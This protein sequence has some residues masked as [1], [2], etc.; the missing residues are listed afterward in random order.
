MNTR[1]KIRNKARWPLTRAG[2]YAIVMA[3]G[4]ALVLLAIR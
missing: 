3:F 1:R 2:N 4:L